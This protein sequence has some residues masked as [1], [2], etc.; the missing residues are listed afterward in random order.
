MVRP[1]LWQSSALFMWIVLPRLAGL[2]PSYIVRQPS[3]RTH[4]G[5]AA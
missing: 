4:V 3:H 2:Q 1:N 5:A